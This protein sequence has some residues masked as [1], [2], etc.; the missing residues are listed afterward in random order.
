[1][2]KV[3]LKL[4]KMIEGDFEQLSSKNLT[5]SMLEERIAYIDSL[6]NFSDSEKKAFRRFYGAFFKNNNKDIKK[7]LEFYNTLPDFSVIEDRAG[8]ETALH[9]YR[10]GLKKSGN[11]ILDC[12]K[13]FPF[14]VTYDI[15]IEKEHPSEIS[16]FSSDVFDAQDYI[17]W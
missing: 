14:L 15:V 4:F 7:L 11:N 12:L 2:K 13:V 6:K 8:I 5:I 10:D 1:M 16:A 17:R 3:A 9:N